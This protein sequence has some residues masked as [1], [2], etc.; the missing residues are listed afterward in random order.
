MNLTTTLL[1]YLILGGTVALAI[2]TTGI[3][4]GSQRWFQ[5]ATAVLF[6]PL[7]V[8]SLLRNSPVGA[9]NGIGTPAGLAERE[10]DISL[11]I[12]QVEVELDL[13]LRSLDGWS[14]AVLAG[15]QRRFEELKAAWHSQAKK[16]HE[17]DEL[18]DQPAFVAAPAPSFA[19]SSA[20]RIA[21]C[22]RA[23]RDNIARLRAVRS[24]LHDDL[25]NTL[26]W[27]RELVTMIHL[28]KYTGAP[29]SRAE[30]LVRQIATAVEG[31]SEVATW[32]HD[33]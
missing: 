27:V 31:L 2:Y 25:L 8:P 29:A 19:D 16:I 11:A 14:D 28:A 26:A 1:F 7:Y 13:A 24:R 21:T 9:S 20:E 33:P 10:D 32:R 18:L 3:A 23:R 22:E 5:T 17:L 30:E 15:E 12:R 6:W 4:A